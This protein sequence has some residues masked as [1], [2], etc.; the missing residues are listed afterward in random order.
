METVAFADIQREIHVPA[1]DAGQVHDQIV[2]ELGF[3]ARHEQR[4]VDDGAGV[5]GLTIRNAVD[6]GGGELIAIARDAV[7][8]WTLL[9]AEFQ[10]T[11]LGIGTE[12]Q[13]LAG[14]DALEGVDRGAQG[15]DLV[16]VA[17]IHAV[18]REDQRQVVARVHHG[19]LPV[20]HGGCRLDRVRI[21]LCGDVL[22]GG[23]V[24]GVRQVDGGCGAGHEG[25]F[26]GCRFGLAD[27][28]P[29]VCRDP[30]RSTG[31]Q[32]AFRN[33][34]G[35]F[36]FGV[37][38]GVA[39]ERRAREHGAG[40]DQPMRAAELNLDACRARARRRWCRLNAG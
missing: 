31:E 36:G 28:R 8:A 25:L 38:G 21:V 26:E 35:P 13:N 24:A 3:L 1:E 2:G 15:H 14:V 18:A 33:F 5:G 34:A 22:S 27:A 10:Q 29:V 7:R 23:Q 16:Q 4:A 40:Q 12:V 30:R 19:L 32:Q 39:Q 9:V 37:V 11:A 17:G 20:V 6:A